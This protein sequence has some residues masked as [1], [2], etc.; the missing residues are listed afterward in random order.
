MNKGSL[1]VALQ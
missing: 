1:I